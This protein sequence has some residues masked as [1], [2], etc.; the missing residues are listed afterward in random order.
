MSGKGKEGN[1]REGKRKV[2]G[3][4]CL[5]SLPLKKPKLP[6]F[7]TGTF[8]QHCSS[9]STVVIVFFLL[10]SICFYFFFGSLDNNCCVS[11]SRFFCPFS[12]FA[13]SDIDFNNWIDGQMDKQSD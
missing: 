10:F 1:E 13:F 4:F 5:S 6:G 12:V 9:S 11:L 7:G 8:Y 3:I 2:E